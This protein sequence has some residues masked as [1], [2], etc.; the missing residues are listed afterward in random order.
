MAEDQGGGPAAAGGGPGRQQPPGGA[1]ARGLAGE[2]ADDQRQVTEIGQR[3]T[4]GFL[5]AGSGGEVM[6]VGLDQAGGCLLGDGGWAARRCRP[7]R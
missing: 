4:R 5:V 1:P 3:G 2:L 7:A 6:L